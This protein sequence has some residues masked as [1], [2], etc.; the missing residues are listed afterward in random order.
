MLRKN[1][2]VLVK[3]FAP[4]CGHCKAM[5]PMYES[6]AAVLHKDSTAILATLD[7][8][9]YKK[10]AKKYKVTK[11]PTFKLYVKGKAHPQHYAPSRE[12]ASAA[13]LVRWVHKKRFGCKRFVAET[14]A[15]E[16]DAFVQFHGRVV[17]G[18][19]TDTTSLAQFQQTARWTKHLAFACMFVSSTNTSSTVPSLVQLIA[20]ESLPPKLPGELLQGI[21]TML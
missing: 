7:A 1:P 14:A 2:F 13:S 20:K 12:E 9:K 18:V 21:N 10:I 11:F 8:S 4:W 16:V 6:A 19:F 17:L 5:K 15:S 3:F